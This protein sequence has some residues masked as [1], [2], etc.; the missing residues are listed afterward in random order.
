MEQRVK[1]WRRFWLA[2]A[3]AACGEEP[4]DPPALALNGG[5]EPA[6]DAAHSTANAL[7][8]IVYRVNVGGPALSGTPTWSADTKSKPSPYGNATATGNQTY[9][10][11]TAV[12]TSDPSIPTGTPASLFKTERWDPAGGAEMTWAFPV[13]PGAYEIHLYF[14][15]I[16]SGLMYAGARKFDV[17][18]EGALVLNDFDVYAAVGGYR[19]VVKSFQ[20]T[21]DA[22]LNI[23]LRHV[24]ENPALKGIEIVRIE[25]QPPPPPAASAPL[26]R[27]NVGGPGLTASDGGVNW[28]AD[29]AAAPSAYGNGSQTGNWTYSTTNTISLTHAS[30]PSGTPAALF[31]TER[32][33][34][35][36]LP[37]MTWRFL[38][39]NGT[40]EVRLY[41]AEIYS[42]ALYTG[43]RRF[44][45]FLEGAK[46]LSAYD[47]FAEVG[48]YRGV[49]K[50][51]QAQVS[52][53]AIDISF[54]HVTENPA[55]KG[56]EIVP[57][58]VQSS[59][60]SCPAASRT[61]AA[62]L[63]RTPYLQQVGQ[64]SAVIAWATT[65]VAQAGSVFVQAAAA[66]STGW[67][68]AAQLRSIPAA[69]G[70][71][72]LQSGSVT[73]LAAGQLYCYEVRDAAGNKVGGTYHFRT[74]PPATTTLPVSFMALGDFG[75]GSAE[76]AAVRDRMLARRDQTGLWLTLGDN[77]YMNGT[78]AQY[79]SYVF[80]YYGELFWNLPFFPTSGN[81]D[82]ETNAAEP[83]L[84]DFFLR[85]NA[86]R[87][88]D[89]ERYYSF[90]WGPVHFVSLDTETPLLQ[91]SSTATDDMRDWL[92][93]DLA[94]TARPWK[95]VYFHKPP[96]SVHPDGRLPSEE[97]RTLLVPVFEQYGV[98]LV[99][100]GH[101]H[102]YERY[103]PLKGGAIS[104]L[105]QGGVTYVVSGGGGAPVYMPGYD[106]RQAFTAGVNHFI[107][108]TADPCTLT[109][110]AID[111]A[112][113]EFDSV[114]LDRC[115]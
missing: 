16:Y 49:M 67:S 83:Y 82:Y 31:Q 38:V 30:L 41:F 99:L 56:I 103:Y 108:G 47:V 5:G 9:S 20:V 36:A 14:A 88:A 60:L 102:S 29:T 61:A 92:A 19:G 17:V 51:L 2:I 84:A 106:A 111:S 105:A 27:V 74:A 101:D 93:A 70:T 79:D 12:S 91:I 3:L 37:E 107:S 32:W 100:S 24:V 114:T 15:E 66:G 18:A 25:S 13:T 54:G 35:A 73:G 76:Q 95:V 28:S 96:Y 46:A 112:G 50:P 94:A 69:S 11:S 48:G 26:Y 115:P 71:L 10:V 53:G 110:R 75:I 81:H 85:R 87:A 63:V 89:L 52:D 23:E 72:S 77:A 8:T 64:T 4:A 62:S 22:T 59:G 97:V 68:T 7:A 34:P 65:P 21:A 58:N 80:G 113:V 42:G 33:D 55:L 57:I 39:N 44:D 98:Q 78:Y 104:T 40:Y 90:D 45:V 43:A 86:W 109:L 1:R 6:Y